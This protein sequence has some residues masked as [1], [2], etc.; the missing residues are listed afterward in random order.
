LVGGPL[1]RGRMLRSSLAVGGVPVRFY[2]SIYRKVIPKRVPIAH[3]FHKVIKWVPPEYVKP[4]HPIRSCDLRPLDK[5]DPN[6]LKLEYRPFADVI[7]KLPPEKRRLFT[8]EYGHRRDAIAVIR[9]DT[10]SLVRCH[11]FDSTS[12]PY[13]IAKSTIRIRSLQEQFNRSEIAVKSG[14]VRKVA[15]ELVDRRRK[16]LRRLRKED[17]KCFEWLLEI[18]GILFKPDYK[19]V[20]VQ[21]K[22]SLNLLVNMYCNEMRDKKMREYKDL[23]EEEK[24][25]FLEMKLNTLQ[26]IKADE[27]SINIQCSVE[28]DIEETKKKLSQLKMGSPVTTM[29]IHPV[30]P[31][32]KQIT[33]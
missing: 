2:T 8:V 25:P 12:L 26:Q 22:A 9:E 33:T 6:W 17:Y 31:S 20:F 15:K 7:D 3:D 23:L 16:Y 1:L 4:W 14:T 30:E 28:E 21:R 24:I 10:L 11:L 29:T 19:Y 18:L 5:T 13:K 32:V 27:D